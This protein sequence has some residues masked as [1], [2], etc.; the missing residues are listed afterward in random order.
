MPVKIDEVK[1]TIS[2]HVQGSN[3]VKVDILFQER[4]KLFRGK[5]RNNARLIMCILVHAIDFRY[6]F[7]IKIHP[8][9]FFIVLI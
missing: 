4:V 7:Y 9:R 2:D 3:K 1:I 8:L 6:T 5:T